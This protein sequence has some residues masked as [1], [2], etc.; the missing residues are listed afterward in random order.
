MIRIGQIGMAHDHAEGKMS[1]VRK[2]PEIFEVVGVAEE[3]PE[4]L[5]RWRHHKTYQDVPLMEVEE[6]LSI[7]DLDAVMVETEELSLVHAAQKCIDRGVHVHLD[8]PAGG[9]VEDFQRLLSDA[10]RKGLT[11]QLAYMY[12][13]NPS[14]QYCAD[15]VKSG[16]L[17]EI[18]RVQAIMNTYHSPEKR[19]WLKQFPGGNMFYLGCHMV[20]LILLMMGTPERIIPFPK[21]TGFDGID[22]TDIGFAVFEY[23]HGIATA[24]AVSVD[25]NGYGRRSLLVCGRKGTIE[26]RPLERCYAD[27]KGE[28]YLSLKEMTEQREYADCRASIPMPQVSG[29][30]DAMMLD[31]AE[32]VRGKKK[33]PFSYEYELLVQKATLAACGLP[34]EVNYTEIN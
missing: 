23:K 2:Y 13:Y 7:P 25:I 27:C 9:N 33:N 28:L 10:K 31:F 22:V 5:K 34:V 6:L 11:V 29:R 26:I 21:S 15:A 24:E 32:M 30:Y 14:V 17:G 8:K 1:C 18:F 20:D 16:K 19:A 4:I 12:R 3:N